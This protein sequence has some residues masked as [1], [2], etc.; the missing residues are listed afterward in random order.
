MAGFVRT[1][2]EFDDGKGEDVLTNATAVRH[3]AD[4]PTIPPV[5]E[6]T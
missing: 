6:D 5:V 4:I 1:G 2:Y 3:T